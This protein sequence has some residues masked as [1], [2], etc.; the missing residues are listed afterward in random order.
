MM[1]HPSYS[2]SSQVP[3]FCELHTII[4][5][6]L[7]DEECGEN[8]FQNQKIKTEKMFFSPAI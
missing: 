2:D 1:S 7:L 3:T 8:N 4:I 6:K 5:I